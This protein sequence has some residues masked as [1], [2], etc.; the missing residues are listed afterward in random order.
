MPSDDW[1]AELE[2]LSAALN[3]P[4]PLRES[5]PAHGLSHVLEARLA[6]AEARHLQ[7]VEQLEE[8]QQRLDKTVP[9][10][11]RPTLLRGGS[12]DA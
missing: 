2:R 1:R 5:L 9:S 12:D 11:P 3:D 4:R 7:L 8:V 10:Q 6:R